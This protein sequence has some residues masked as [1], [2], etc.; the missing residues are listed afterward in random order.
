VHLVAVTWQDARTF[1]GWHPV[2]EPVAA[3][4]F[5][6]RSVGWI[7]PDAQHRHLVIAQTLDPVGNGGDLLSIPL[8]MVRRVERL[9]AAGPQTLDPQ[10]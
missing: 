3:E 1:A 4:P 2:G 8:G 6:Q 9:A 7:M 10:P 5:L